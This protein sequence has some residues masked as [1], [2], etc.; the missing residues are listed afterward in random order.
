MKER[1]IPEE[2]YFGLKTA[3]GLIEFK[4]RSKAHKQQWVDGIKK[5]LCRVSSLDE[6]E[7]SIGLLSISST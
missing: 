4:C 7:R 2:V 3:Q 5:L 1:E 6:A